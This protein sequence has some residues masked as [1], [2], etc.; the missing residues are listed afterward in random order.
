MFIVHSFCCA[1]V[2]IS[3]Q[4]GGFYFTHSASANALLTGYRQVFHCVT[5]DNC[6]CII[7]SPFNLSSFVSQPYRFPI[8]M[9]LKNH[10]LIFGREIWNKQNKNW[11]RILIF[12]PLHQRSPSLPPT[13]LLGGWKYLSWGEDPNMSV[14]PENAFRMIP[15]WSQ[16]KEEEIRA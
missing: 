14:T 4:S 7:L 9:S 5:H 12:A 16:E 6:R 2:Q 1:F 10:T 13:P 8:P 15:R 3:S 11:N